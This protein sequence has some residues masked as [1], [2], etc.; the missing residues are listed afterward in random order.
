VARSADS[1]LNTFACPFA[2]RCS[3]RVKFRIAA[4]AFKIKLEAQGEHTAESHVQDKVSKFLSIQQSA[5]L[6]QM[7]S[8]NPMVSATSCRRG[9]ELLPDPAAHISPSKQRLVARAVSAAILRT[10]QPFSHGEKLEGEEGS[11]TRLSAKIY[12]HTIVEEHNLGGKH[13]ELH[14]PVCVGH[15]FKDGVVFGCYSTPMLLLHVA[16]GINSAWP[17]LA[18]FDTTFGITSKKCELMGISVNSLRRRANPVCLCVVKKEEAI[19]YEKMY[20]SME[21]GVFELVHNMKLC[22]VSG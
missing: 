13:L 17:L 10:L 6:E 19:A 9:L 18:G 4:T 8:T 12:L 7:V 14:Q 21:G 3:C 1:T 15:Q 16:R 11:L 22:G 2:D 20:N 5:A